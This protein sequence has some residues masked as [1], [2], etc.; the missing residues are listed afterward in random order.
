MDATS[1]FGFGKCCTGCYWTG[2]LLCTR[3]GALVCTPVE[4]VLM[5]WHQSRYAAMPVLLV[6]EACSQAVPEILSC[7]AL[8]LFG[9]QPTLTRPCRATAPPLTSLVLVSFSPVRCSLAAGTRCVGRQHFPGTHPTAVVALLSEQ[10]K[11]SPHLLSLCCSLLVRTAANNLA[12]VG[13]SNVGVT[14]QVG[15]GE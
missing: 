13:Q 6:Q 3:L 8:L 4:T 7:L 12:D 11:G 10:L 1:Q 15:G 9:L 2:W 14:H 5:P